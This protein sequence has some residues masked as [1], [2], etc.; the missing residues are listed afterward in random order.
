M[1]KQ[2]D[3]HRFCIY[4]VIIYYFTILFS[5]TLSLPQFSSLLANLNELLPTWSFFCDSIESSPIVELVSALL[6]L[7]VLSL[8]LTGNISFDVYSLRI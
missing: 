8:L 1:I 5:M 3:C 7:L 4:H 2:I 6:S